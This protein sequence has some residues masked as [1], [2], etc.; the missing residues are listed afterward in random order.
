MASVAARVETTAVQEPTARTRPARR[1]SGLTGGVAWIVVVA[2]LLAG[3]VA[4]NVSVLGLNVELS[5]VQARRAS[6]QAENAE[7]EARLSSAAAATRIQRSAEAAGLVP[8]D[9]AQVVYVRLPRP[10]R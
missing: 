10:K 8:T 3:V 5:E 1:R 2:V 7:L 4:V 6:L 9:P